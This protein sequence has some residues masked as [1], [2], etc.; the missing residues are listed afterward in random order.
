MAPP[1]RHRDIAGKLHLPAVQ[2]MVSDQNGRG[3]NRRWMK[4]QW[5]VSMVID[6]YG[7]TPVF[8][9]AAVILMA[10]GFILLWFMPAELKTDNRC[11][12]R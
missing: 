1:A 11:K 7:T 8:L 12:P 10:L 5:Q 6:L 4:V 2:R 3:S 9:L